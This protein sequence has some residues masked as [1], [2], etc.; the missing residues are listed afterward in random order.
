VST[1]LTVAVV[2]LNFGELWVP[3]YHA[4]PDVS[5]VVLC[6]PV[7]DVLDRVGEST[8]IVDR[9]PSLDHVL[10]DPHID[11]VHLL[12]PLDLHAS[13]TFAT[14]T[15]GKHCAVAVT[16][17]LAMAELH[18]IVRL[19]N[20]TGGVDRIATIVINSA[21]PAAPATCCN[22]GLCLRRVAR[23]A[24]TSAC[25]LDW[26]RTVDEES[27]FYSWGEAGPEGRGR[28]VIAVA[29][30]VAPPH[31]RVVLGETN[32]SIS[33]TA[34]PDMADLWA[35]RPAAVQSAATI[36]SIVGRRA[37]TMLLTNS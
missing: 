24:W 35:A 27:L 19:Q 22:L 34:P 28:S 18:E 12:T 5:R 4:H 14:M 15:A 25:R 31:Y 16:P 36:A 17:A 1:G 29:G 3:I 7:P 33:T 21:E 6:D 20:E 26:G 37:S 30:A 11:A 32:R 23:N 9:V 8:G 2:G 10:E 13:Q